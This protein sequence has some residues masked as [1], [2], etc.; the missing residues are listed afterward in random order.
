MIDS[1]HTESHKRPMESRTFDPMP[2][3]PETVHKEPV[4]K[5]PVRKQP[6]KKEEEPTINWHSVGAV[7]QI[8]L[9]L[10]IAFNISGLNTGSPTGAVVADVPTPTAAAPTP[11]PAAPVDMEALLDDDHV[12]GDADAPVT[13]VEFSDF[14]CP[15]CARFYSQTYKQ[16]EEQYIKTGKVKLVYR[17]FPLG[18]HANAQ[19]AA[20]AAECAGEQG[21]YYEMHDILFEDGV[22]GGVDTFKKYAQELKL[23]K[24]EFDKCL[25]SGAMA[26]EVRK[27]FTDG[28]RAGIQGTPG[29]L[30]NGQLISGAQPFQVFQQVIEAELAN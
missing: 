14:E 12:N 1:E 27:D 26:A 25:D 9:L 18:F 13:I 28:Q 6:E 3:H 10:Y 30:V 2:K 15:F 16:I 20:E 4:H 11:Q 19:K 22:V 7:L 17:D 24:G 29:F 5:D 21:K 8:V 23:N